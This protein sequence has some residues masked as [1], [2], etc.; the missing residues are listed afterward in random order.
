MMGCMQLLVSRFLHSSQIAIVPFITILVGILI[1]MIWWCIKSLITCQQEGVV[2]LLPSLLFA[3]MAALLTEAQDYICDD[4]PE[5]N[6]GVCECDDDVCY[7]K[8]VIEHLQT[9]TAYE[10]TPARGTNGRVYYLNSNGDLKPATNRRTAC[11][12]LSQCTEVHTVDGSTYRSFVAINKQIPAPTLI[13][14][15]GATVVVDVFNYLTTEGTSIHWHGVHQR[16][17]PWMDGVGYISQCPIE[18]GTSFRYIFKAEPSG[19]FWYHSHTGPQRTVLL[20]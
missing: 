4:T 12:D 15:E 18:A 5:K 11:E 17:T 8:F 7:F 9:F 3:L 20:L 1:I 6:M 13:V 10:K 16:K 19:T 2:M 14:N